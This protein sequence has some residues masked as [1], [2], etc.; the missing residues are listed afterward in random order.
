MGHPSSIS[1]QAAEKLR[2]AISGDVILPGERGYDAA[3]SAWVL[4]SDQRP[5]VV[6]L[7][8]SAADVVQAVRF[9]RSQGIRV[10]PQGTGHGSGSLESLG[11][12]M[13]VRT[14]SMR[15]VEVDPAT[16]TARAE[17]GARWQDVIVPAGAHGLAALAGTSA[18]V[19]VA[20][21][22][23]GGGLG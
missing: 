13:L 3:R 18:N 11:D 9:A 4:T 7:V 5:A 19:G 16:R 21:Y 2:S 15:A 17:A 1:S 23:L 12:A 20:G 8:R 6:V 10:A 22:T 14:Q